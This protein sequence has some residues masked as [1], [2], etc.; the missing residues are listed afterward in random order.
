ML[1]SIEIIEHVSK[2]TNIH[3]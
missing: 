3:C 2:S 1:S